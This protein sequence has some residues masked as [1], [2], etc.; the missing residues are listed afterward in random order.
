MPV[1]HV[2]WDAMDWTPVRPGI[3]RKAFSGHGATLALHRLWPGHETRPHAHANEQVVWILEGLVD[4]H[5]GDDVLR[6]GPG[7]LAVVPP[8]VVHY[9][10]VVGT[11]PALNLD[12]FTPSRPEYA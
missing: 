4:F 10:E 6:L 7:G 12:V 1:H 5:I 9:A 11:S 8:N 3:E 2:D